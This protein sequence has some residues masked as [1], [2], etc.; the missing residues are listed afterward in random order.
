[1]EE[2]KSLSIQYY[3]ESDIGLVRTENQD[4]FGKFPKD[5]TNLA[6]PKGVLFIVADG[7][8]GHTG[9]KEASELVVE[10]IYDQLYEE[11]YH[12]IIFDGS[13]LSSGV[14]LYRLKAGSFID[15]GKMILLR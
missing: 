5:N 14:F 9:G 2:N 12:E 13:L 15:S 6:Q 4:C 3:G 11:G 10:L 1:M 8:G 7:M